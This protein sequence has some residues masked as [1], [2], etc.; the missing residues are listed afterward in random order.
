MKKKYLL[1]TGCAGFIGSNFTQYVLSKFK[2]LYILGLDNLSYSSNP[3]EKKFFVC[4]KKY[5]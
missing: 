2:N 1:I 3:K 4:E 5:F